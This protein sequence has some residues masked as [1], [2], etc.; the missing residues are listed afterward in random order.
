[1]VIVVW[2][3]Y[4][5]NSLCLLAKDKQRGAKVQKILKQSTQINEF[6]Q[7]VESTEKVFNLI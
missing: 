2:F 3:N 7:V 6:L 1:M 4:Y 5:F